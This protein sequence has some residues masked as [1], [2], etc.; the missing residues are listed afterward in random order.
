MRKI[1]L[2]LLTFLSFIGCKDNVEE[3]AL[4]YIESARTAFESEKYSEAKQ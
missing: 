1:T 2:V 4:R 3:L